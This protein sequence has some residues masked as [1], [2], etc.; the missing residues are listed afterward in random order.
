MRRATQTDIAKALGLSPSTVGLVVGNNKSPLRK[1]LNKET[2]R[3]IEEKA[4]ELGYQPNRAA[5][6][7]RGSRTNLIV[8]LNMGGMAEWINRQA[9][10]VGMLAHELGYDYQVIDAFWWVMK[11]NRIIDQ[12]IAMRPEGVIISGNP[13]AEMDFSRLNRARIPLVTLDL[14]LPETPCVRHDV[15]GAIFDLTTSCISNGRERIALLVRDETPEL[16]QV[17]ERVSGFINALKAAGRTVPQ[18]FDLN[19]LKP[20]SLCAPAVI[21]KDSH[22]SG[23]FEPFQLGHRAAER[24]GTMVDAFILGNDTYAIGALT[25]YLRNKIDIPKQVAL[26]GFDNL[27]YTTE[28]SVP[29]TTV[30]FPV[31]TMCKKAME[32][33]IIQIEGTR[34]DSEGHVFPCEIIWRNS[35]PKP[36]QA[37]SSTSRS[38]N[39]SL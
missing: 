17:R 12:V 22:P 39:L 4:K 5:Q 9:F 19:D 29:L 23:H 2:V 24:V 27:A 35:M 32:L 14:E 3:R 18:T 13:Q 20:G 15:A 8:F 38:R 30:A 11:G 7:M 36:R 21:L 28:G 16:W 37:R 25:Y 6:A 31:A 33:L 26:S 34:L 1:H 10:Q